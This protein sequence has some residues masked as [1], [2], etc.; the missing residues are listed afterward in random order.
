LDEAVAIGLGGVLLICVL[1]HYT[2]RKRRNNPD[3]QNE[4]LLTKEDES[5]RST[6]QSFN[7]IEYKD[8]QFQETIGRGAEG[9]VRKGH[10]QGWDVA[11]K[12]III[13]VSEEPAEGK[14]VIDEARKEA[15][16]HQRLRHPHIVTFYGLATKLSSMDVKLAIVMGL[17]VCS[18][19]DYLKSLDKQDRKEAEEDAEGAK[20]KHDK[21][22][23][24]LLVTILIQVSECWEAYTGAECWCRMH[25]GTSPC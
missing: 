24:E 20:P 3:W 15:E 17:C 1:L 11:I 16:I 25:G 9:I 8:L 14:G 21:A 10:W 19:K 18:L 5:K 7:S 22:V 4:P 12:V 13:G 6:N 23:Q 2:R